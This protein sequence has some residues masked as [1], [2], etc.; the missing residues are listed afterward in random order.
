MEEG[1]KGDI[2][3]GP[4]KGKL[5]KK[6]LSIRI[7]VCM[8][9]TAGIK[10]IK[11]AVDEVQERHRD[12]SFSITFFDG[13]EADLKYTENY[14]IIILDVGIKDAGNLET[15]REIRKYNKKTKLIFLAD[16]A[17]YVNEAFK[18]KAYRYLSRGALEAELGEALA[19]ILAECESLEGM[20]IERGGIY[21]R[22]L[23]KDILYVESLGDEAVIYFDDSY[24]TVR[25][26]LYNLQQLGSEFYRCH[27]SYIINLRHIKEIKD[28]TAVLKMDKAIPI[29]ARRKAGLKEAYKEYINNNMD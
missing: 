8:H 2:G 20:E 13:S 21:K 23:L 29:A 10:S 5:L 14:D 28:N 3:M 26:T 12:I 22:I 9:E 6:S 25:Q 15:A 19:D 4:K 16:H 7:A 27:K 18:L 24:V 17:D 11:S 1:A